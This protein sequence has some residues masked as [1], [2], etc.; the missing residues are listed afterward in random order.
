[1]K[2][3]PSDLPQ[4]IARNEATFRRINEDIGRGRDAGDDVT[5]IGFVCECGHADCAR[6]IELTPAEYEHVRSSPTDFAVVSGHEIEGVERV[7]ERR[8]RYTVVRK[9][10]SGGTIALAT[11]P[12]S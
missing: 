7:L 1:V 3:V 2:V 10:D 8:D 5:L 4:R 11:D 12:R 9:L 6:L